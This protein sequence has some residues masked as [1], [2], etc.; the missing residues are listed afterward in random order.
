[1]EDRV[2]LKIV[3]F[4]NTIALLGGFALVLE[5]DEMHRKIPII[6][7]MSEAQAIAVKLETEIWLFFKS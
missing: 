3:G 1:M 2:K 7:G 5:D 4:T 6:I